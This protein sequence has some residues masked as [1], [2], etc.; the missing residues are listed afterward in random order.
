M[1]SRILAHQRK[2]VAAG[3]GKR[4]EREAYSSHGGGGIVGPIISFNCAINQLRNS[5]TKDS[6]RKF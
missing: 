4:Q 6:L 5:T 3:E 2:A 1:G